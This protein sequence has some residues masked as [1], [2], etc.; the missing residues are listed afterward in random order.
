MARVRYNLD[1]RPDTYWGKQLPSH[2]S[3]TIATISMPTEPVEPP[4][5]LD[6]V[7]GGSYIGGQTIILEARG[8]A[9]K[10][11]YR[12]VD[13]FKR[14]FYFRPTM[15][16]LP[17]TM[18]ELISLL[19]SVRILNYEP[20]K[21]ITKV[22]RQ[23][24]LDELSPSDD[25]TELVDYV[26]VK[27]KFYPELESYYTEEA[28]EWVAEAKTEWD[29]VYGDPTEKPDAIDA[30]IFP[31]DFSA[32]EDQFSSPEDAWKNCSRSDWMLKILQHHLQGSEVDQRG[33]R[34]FA[35][36]CA[37]QIRVLLDEQAILTRDEWLN[38]CADAVEASQRYAAGEVDR[39]RL[40]YAHACVENITHHP[41]HDRLE[42]LVGSY[43]KA[44]EWASD[45]RGPSHPWW[46]LHC[47]EFSARHMARAAGD[48]AMRKAR[49]VGPST[50]RLWRQE[51][52]AR[53][54]AM[55]DQANTL[56]DL[57]GS[58]FAK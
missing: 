40:E 13:R 22:L 32:F 17:L 15:S 16:L 3:A 29:K 2:D 38:I 42:S 30:R 25:P 45:D 44:C 20:V 26:R 8:K 51:K 19:E 18:S 50:R 55:S 21:G 24:A 43:I 39:S 7:F 33:L 27:S 56:R 9:G 53:F 28:L 31:E 34:L 41:D 46:I 6:N 4:D 1:Y 14:R 58:P 23:Y 35:C 10:I 57:L 49:S 52:A 5:I 37:I 54:G 12:F 11:H 47:A 48:F 36:W